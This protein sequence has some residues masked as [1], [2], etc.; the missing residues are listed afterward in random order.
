[1]LPDRILKIRR[2]PK[3]ECCAITN[4][5]YS[6]GGTE[7]KSRHEKVVNKKLVRKKISEYKRLVSKH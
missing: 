3:L 5:G 7:G 2:G 6:S 1:M 4:F